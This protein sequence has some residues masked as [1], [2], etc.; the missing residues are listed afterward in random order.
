MFP[1]KKYSWPW[2]NCEGRLL[3]WGAKIVLHPG[4]TTEL[5]FV[6]QV[7]KNL[8]DEQGESISK[9]I[10]EGLFELVEVPKDVSGLK[11]RAAMKRKREHSIAEDDS[12]KSDSDKEVDDDKDDN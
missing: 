1:T 3:S 10:Q 8:T 11:P 9:D 4:A 7:S 12:D 6:T 5:R 2:I